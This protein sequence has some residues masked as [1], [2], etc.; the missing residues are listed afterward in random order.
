[1]E[2]KSQNVICQNCKVNFTIESD[3]FSFYEKIKVPPPTFCPDCRLQRR[4]SWKNIMS[5]YNDNCKICKKPVI[6]LYSRDSNIIIYCNKCWWSD[7]WDPKD[8]ATD[9]DFSRPFFEQF[10]EFT[11]KIPH[12]AIVNDDGISSLN[13]EYSHDCWYSKNCYMVFNSW[14]IENVSY[15]VLII[16]GRD[17]VDCMDI[18]VDTSWMYESINCGK[19]YQLKYSELCT[20]CVDSY[21]LYDCRD[22]SDCF[23]C[24]GL[25][26][27]KYYFKNKQYTK[28]EYNKI[29]IKYELETFSGV[30]KAKKDFFEFLRDYHNRYAQIIQC[31]NSTGDNIKNCKNSKFCFVATNCENCKYYDLSD[32]G[33]DSYD[34]TIA[35]KLS[36]C[37][38]GM[39]LDHS[40]LNLFGIYSVKSQD[41]RYTEYCHNCKH[42]FAC[43][44]L[45]NSNYCILNKQYTKEQYEQMMPKIIEHMNNMPYIDKKGNEYKFGEFYPSELSPFG[46]NE[47]QAPEQFPLSRDEVLSQGLK[48]QDNIQRTIGKETI[49]SEDIPESINNI[50]DSITEEILSCI[51]C[52]RN[53]RIVPNELTF[54]RKMTIPIPRRCFYC[55]HNNRV[56]RRNPFKLW[57]RKCMKK[58][59]MNEFETS[60]SPDRSEIIYCEQC[61]QQEVY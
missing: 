51:E 48:W 59:C 38:E 25:R 20:A 16:A 24:S 43:S 55:R 33:K 45:K 40:Q 44:N 21:F 26:G 30:E 22:C 9:Y 60:Y 36:Q 29:L 17:M 37:Y 27:K 18:L 11:K 32:G 34:L 52:K 19:S 57:H 5:L 54:Y 2:H 15:S 56:Q 47:T 39:V 28:E 12:M 58:G 14:Y 42:V 23:M 31:L 49:K 35:G 41:I 10:N 3:D 1:M 7:K 53:Y 4:Y 13:S 6:S 46:Y 50:E 61:Y 8:Y